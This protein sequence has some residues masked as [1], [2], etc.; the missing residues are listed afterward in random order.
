MDP[1]LL[2][3][4]FNVT[5]DCINALNTTVTCDA[6]LLQ[7]AGSVDNYLW[8]IDN[9]TSLCTPECLSSTSIW[10]T[11]VS[12]QCADDTIN[13]NGRL[14]PPITIPGRVLDGMNIACLTPDTN[15]LMDPGVNGSALTSTLLSENNSSVT[16]DSTA[17]T[18]TSSTD[19]DSSTKRKRQTS[20]GGSGSSSGS[21]FCLIESYSWVGSDIIRPDCTEGTTT[22]TDNSTSQC[23][24]PT[25]VPPDNERIANLY[26]NTLLCSDCFIKSFY[27]RVA[28]PYLPDLDYSDYLVS[29]YFDIIDVCEAEM[30][31]LL[32]RVLPY[33]EYAP[34]TYD[35]V[36]DTTDNGT[37]S[38]SSG[39][40]AV[41]CGQT[42]GVKELSSLAVP[43]PNANG[44]IYCDA[45]SNTYN[46]TTGDLQ[47][48]FDDYFCLPTLNFTSVCV[49]A[50]CT[51]MQVPNNATWFVLPPKYDSLI[52]LTIAVTPWQR[53]SQ[54][55]RI[56]SLRRNS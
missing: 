34:N 21:S 56:I 44:S 1:A 45:I 15:V 30:P 40:P 12:S 19:P 9:V 41:A 53:R 28:S 13:V 22:T 23:S 35:G 39:N 54:R 50:G 55:L 27:L 46:V 14:V 10:F 31:D 38:S 25:D 7:M 4:A 32:V 36:P 24:D 42:L 17:P 11:D 8:D 26:P 18:A 3:S 48:A 43:D 29:Q 49:P 37:S 52:K 33:Y 47:L 6:T 2:A 5:T 51:L 16:I 20:G